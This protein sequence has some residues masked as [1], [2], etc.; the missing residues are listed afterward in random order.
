M[1]HRTKGEFPL[2]RFRHLALSLLAFTLA[3]SAGMAAT[4]DDD[5]YIWLEDTYGAKPIEWVEAE[6][7]RTFA[8]LKTDPR[9]AGFYAEALKIVQA[10]DRIPTP[11]FLDGAIVNFWRDATHVQGVWRTTSKAEFQKAAPQWK[12]LIDLDALG[13]AEGKTWVWKGAVCEPQGERRCLVQLSDG[14]EDAVSV[15]EFDVPS[16]AF[17]E[18]G[19]NLPTSK[20][21]LA[22]MDADT[23]LVARDWGGGT[24]TASGYPF[25]VKALRRG[26]PLTEAKEVYRGAAS[27]V[28]VAPFSL[29]DGKGNRAIGIVRA[30]T[31]FGSE[32]YLLTDKGAAKLPF[33]D[34]SDISGL[35]DGRMIV[36]LNEAWTPEGSQPIA[37][38]AIVAVDLAALRAGT[39]PKV[40][41]LFSPGP[42]QSVDEIATTRSAVIASIYDNVRGRA[43][44]F[45]PAG[46]GW[47]QRDLALPD[48]ASITV[49]AASERT[50]D[51]YA[52]VTGFLTPNS[53][54][55]IDTASGAAL[56]TKALPAKFDASGLVVEQYEATSTDGTK[57]PYFVVHR[58][59]IVR[60]GTTPTIMTAYGGFQ[61]SNTPYYAPATGKLWLER[62]GA[63]V[64]ANIRGGGE[65]GPAW[66][67][68]GLKTKRQIIYDDF[69]AVGED[70]IARGITSARRLG[71]YGGSNGGLLMGVEFN[72]RPDLWNA[73][74]IQVPL[75][76]MMRYEQIAAGASWVDEY[77]SVSI[78][79]ERAFLE[80]ISPYRNVKKGG[81]Y[82]EP[83]IW[84]TTKDDRV[85]PVHA[86]KFAARLKEYGIPYL[87]YENIAGGHSGDSNLNQVAERNALEMTYFTRKLMDSR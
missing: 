71:I 59:D 61:V 29:I 49:T 43:V 80:Q 7:E 55:S 54:W 1:I 56:E 84:T 14:G 72:Q 74:V 67:E 17:V 30:T 53:L 78:P 31:F 77:G 42:R 47:A 48:N 18:S 27:D 32:K 45:T 81:H 66:H 79:E 86:R 44:V 69:A 28:G 16:A 76:D 8:V 11:A 3:G 6:N 73:V 15:R 40:E 87:Y 21:D 22:W 2:M 85:G 82:P 41:T 50:D 26:A 34:K 62:G 33:P 57:I 65:F 58:R 4:T 5:P 36:R 38:G 23:L 20:Q 10:E 60:D 13:K 83:F 35:V 68:A 75:L 37:A 19:F 52:L 70:L 51:A 46:T 12:T 24:M 64:V 63:F 25:V 9:Y 39:A